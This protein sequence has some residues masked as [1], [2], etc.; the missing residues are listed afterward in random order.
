MS[1]LSQE[2]AE[3]E[4]TLGHAAKTESELDA[5]V[6]QLYASVT[7]LQAQLTEVSLGQQKCDLDISSTTSRIEQTG[8]LVQERQG[9]RSKSG[10]GELMV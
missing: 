8:N 10:A 5:I 6:R 4:K 1:R 3:L 7:A 2:V 9:A